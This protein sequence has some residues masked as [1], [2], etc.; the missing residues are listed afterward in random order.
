MNTMHRVNQPRK[1]KY[2]RLSQN[3]GT[4][5]CREVSPRWRRRAQAYLGQVDRIM[6]GGRQQEPMQ[7]KCVCDHWLGPT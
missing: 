4:V 6:R 1:I 7:E 3:T 2:G 5:L